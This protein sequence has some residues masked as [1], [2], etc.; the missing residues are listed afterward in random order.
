VCSPQFSN[1]SGYLPFSVPP[2]L[3]AAVVTIAVNQSM[4]NLLS[5]AHKMSILKFGPKYRVEANTEWLF[6][7][8]IMIFGLHYIILCRFAITL[9]R[10]QLSTID[11]A[12]QLH[13][14]TA[15]TTIHD[16]IKP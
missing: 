1:R 11:N 7:F 3:T 2:V 10:F 14:K 4:E 5:V 15:D 16:E 9:K 8:V 6:M 12:F 13:G